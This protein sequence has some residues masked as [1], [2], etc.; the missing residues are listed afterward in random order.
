M[1]RQKLI[2]LDP[3]SWELAQKKKNFSEWV[4]K[5]LRLEVDGHSLDSLTTDY[6]FMYD[7]KEYWM[8]KYNELKAQGESE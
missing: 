2:T 1:M 8:K 3:T 5:Q 6:E 7:A 4:R